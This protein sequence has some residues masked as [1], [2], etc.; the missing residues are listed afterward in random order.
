MRCV[1]QK[2][3]TSA[4]SGGENERGAAAAAQQGTDSLLYCDCGRKAEHGHSA[5]AQEWRTLRSCQ[6]RSRRAA[7]TSKCGTVGGKIA[8]T[9]PILSLTPLRLHNM[10][11]LT[12]TPTT[13]AENWPLTTCGGTCYNEDRKR[14]W[15][16]RCKGQSPE[17]GWTRKGIDD[18]TWYQHVL[19]FFVPTKAERQ[20]RR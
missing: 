6:G 2:P 8:A 19:S 13:R 11:W 16:R 20:R 1:R 17:R 4:L 3:H 9:A 14:R 15:Y 18:S 10:L 12:A 7:R 5:R